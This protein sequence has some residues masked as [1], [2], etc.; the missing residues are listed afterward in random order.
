MSVR[1]RVRI[2][3][4]ELPDEVPFVQRVKRLLKFA[5]RGCRLRAVAISWPP[6]PP[7]PAIRWRVMRG[8]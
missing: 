1:E 7:R 5:L 3:L 6:E 8:R 4:E 2:E